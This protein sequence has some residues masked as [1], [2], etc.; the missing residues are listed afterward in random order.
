[1]FTRTGRK[2]GRKNTG[3]ERGGRKKGRSW[4]REKAYIGTTRGGNSQAAGAA[5]CTGTRREKGHKKC[6]Q[7]VASRSHSRAHARVAQVC[8]CINVPKNPVS[9]GAILRPSAG[10][11]R[12]RPEE[13]AAS[14][15][16]SE[17]TSEMRRKIDAAPSAPTKR[18]RKRKRERKKGGRPQ[19]KY[20]RGPATTT[21]MRDK[22]ISP[23]YVKLLRRA[24]IS[25]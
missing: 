11:Y 18:E 9:F 14:I 7:K 24:R 5:S 23:L 1:M 20:I 12:V 16:P 2:K 15:L 19:D 8:V 25:P 3:V 10:H 21:T 17:R 13:I 22:E 4:G 6:R